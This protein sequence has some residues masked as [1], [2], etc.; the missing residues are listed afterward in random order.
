MSLGIII[1]VHKSYTYV[2]SSVVTLDSSNVS[3]SSLGII[4]AFPL[5]GS[6]KPHV[7]ENNFYTAR[8]AYLCFFVLPPLLQ[9]FA[10]TITMTV[11]AVVILRINTTA[12]TTIP[13]I[14]P[15][16]L[17]VSELVSNSASV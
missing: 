9:V 8:I 5:I 1:M 12:T 10:S 17:S 3:S 6:D 2:G 13:P 7:V 15:A 16:V 4:V 11:T 14:I